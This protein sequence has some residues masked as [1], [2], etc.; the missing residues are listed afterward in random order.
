MS[1]RLKRN[2]ESELEDSWHGV[3]D[4]LELLQYQST[5]DDCVSLV[6]E[7]RRDGEEI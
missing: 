4:R 6:T 5:S 2:D 1:L 3:M 7:P